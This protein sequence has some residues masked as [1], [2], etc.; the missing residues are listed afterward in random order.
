MIVQHPNG[1]RGIEI[2]PEYL[3]IAILNASQRYRDAKLWLEA[4]LAAADNLRE[5]DHEHAGDYSSESEVTN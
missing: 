4:L 2:A 5:Q 1:K 3:P